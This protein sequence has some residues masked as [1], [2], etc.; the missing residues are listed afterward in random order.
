MA[1]R[2]GKLY[3]LLF[4]LRGLGYEMK[5]ILIRAVP[6]TSRIAT[7]TQAYAGASVGDP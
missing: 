3:L 5:K 7:P 2:K 6:G 1:T 4:D